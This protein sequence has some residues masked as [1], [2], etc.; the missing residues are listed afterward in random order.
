MNY[1]SVALFYT[2]GLIVAIV[3]IT[4]FAFSATLLPNNSVKAQAAT[5]QSAQREA[6]AAEIKAVLD[7]LNSPDNSC[8]QPIKDRFIP[9]LENSLKDPVNNKI[10][11][12]GPYIVTTDD[13]GAPLAL[14]CANAASLEKIII[15]GF[16]VI[17]SLY[18]LVLA[19]AIIRAG[20]L[21][22]TSFANSDQFEAGL[23]SFITAVIYTI[24]GLFGY[25]I[26]V[27]IAVGVIGVGVN[28]NKPEY[29]LFCQ[30]RIIFNLTFDQA[31]P[32]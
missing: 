1:K 2:K 31:Q 32:C 7:V 29:N 28:A 17:F 10:Y 5:P 8:P 22:M 30:N 15:R 6:D 11:L 12:N 9:L 26:F 16:M 3:T 14:T 4:L 27:F 13:N 24:A 21:M 25:T 18:G 23:K 19:F 20:I